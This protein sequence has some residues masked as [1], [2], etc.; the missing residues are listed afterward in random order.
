MQARDIINCF[1]N[2]LTVLRKLIRITLP[3]VLILFLILEFI[4]FRFVLPASEWPYRRIITKDDPVVRYLYK[5]APMYSTGVW[6]LGFP[7][8]YAARY[9]INHE[10]WNST[11]E[12]TSAKSGK[13][14]IAVIG[15]SFVDALQV[16]VDQCFAELLEADLNQ[17]HIPEVEVYRF[18]FGNASMSQYLQVLRYVAKKFDP[19]IVIVS[20]QANDFLTSILPSANEDGDF[21]QF[22]RKGEKWEE[23]PP[24]AYEPN[25]LRLFLKH[26]AIFRYIYGNL[27]FRYRNFR[28]GSLLKKQNTAR[29]YQ[30]NV[31]I[32]IDLYQIELS[33][34]LSFHILNEMKTA[35]PPQ[36]KLLVFMDGDR[37]AIYHGY[38]PK[39]EKSYQLIQMLS[40][41]C[42]ESQIPFLELSEPF[43]TDYKKFHERFDYDIDRHWN[44]R[45]HRIVARTLSA[46]FRQNGW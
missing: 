42:Q 16:N 7:E 37:D 24:V 27:E 6:R 18:G 39:R 14:R 8:R 33:R 15:D 22:A 1:L 17:D 46:F 5:D 45:G 36:A 41:V 2:M 12:Y 28:L 29:T 13:K 32:R 9:K 40:E 10:G 23:V 26:S 4:V 38:D 19:D 30:M 35:L 3:S 20:I 34:D 21:L 11:K 44:E 25:Q 31:D 43:E